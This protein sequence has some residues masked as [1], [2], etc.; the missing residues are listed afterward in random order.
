MYNYLFEIVSEWSDNY[1]KQFFVQCD[2]REKADEIL[3]QCFW[4]EKVKYIGKY[5]D[6]EIEM[7]S[8]DEDD[9]E[10]IMLGC[11]IC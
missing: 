3:S 4:G 7:M 11:D 1:G 2:T 10:C 9:F 5:T 8:D 6:E